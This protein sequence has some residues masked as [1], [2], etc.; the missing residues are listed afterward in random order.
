MIAWPDPV[1]TAIAR[2]R[3]V[4]LIGSGV[5]ANAQTDGGKKPPTWGE[6]LKAGY[7]KV[8]KRLAYIQAALNTYGY[9]EACEYIR[10]EMGEQWAGFIRSEF[11]TPN[12]KPAK[13]HEAIF[14][15]DSRIVASLNFDKIYENYAIKA[16]ED[17]VIV[18][19]YYDA[20]MREAVSGVDRYIIKPHGTVDTVSK[21][22]FTLEQYGEARTLHSGFY[23]VFSSLLHTH[24]FICV[25]C[26]LS[27]PDL[28]LIFEDYKYRHKESPHFIVLPGPLPAPK[29][30]LIRRTRGMTVLTYNP[31]DG[32]AE[33]TASLQELGSLVATKRDEIALLRSW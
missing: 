13:I 33:L 32:H 4:I 10:S 16:S 8:G 3:S 22:I 18:K 27:D 17:T 30:D 1:I 7:A 23:D 9:L 20:D 21:L 11:A 31:K 2:R 24:T 6:F 26:G 19:S 12:Y 14:E 29:R 25:G 28:Q 5:S 15:L